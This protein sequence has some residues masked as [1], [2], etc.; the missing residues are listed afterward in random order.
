MLSCAVG[1]NV[2]KLQ[3]D[4]GLWIVWKFKFLVWENVVIKFFFNLAKTPQVLKEKKILKNFQFTFFLL[5]AR[6]FEFDNFRE[7]T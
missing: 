4:G 7:K 5:W 2:G 3:S 1:P 6:I